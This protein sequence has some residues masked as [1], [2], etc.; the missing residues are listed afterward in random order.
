VY[1][2]EDPVH[3]LALLNP[4]WDSFSNLIRTTAGR[5]YVLATTMFHAG[6][7][8]CQ[9]GNVF[10]CRTTRERGS[11]LGFFSNR[12]LLLS[13]A[14]E[15]GLILALIYIPPLASLFEHLP[16]PA[17]YW[18]L[19]A[20]YGPILYL[21]EKFRKSLVRRGVFARRGEILPSPAD[22]SAEG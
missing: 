9:V 10:S 2:K 14:V 18:W 21:I 4:V 6:V 12:F 20:L 8:A 16:I 22:R 7:V 5:T 3:W 19:L 13:V 11:K 15:T 1:Y 17:G